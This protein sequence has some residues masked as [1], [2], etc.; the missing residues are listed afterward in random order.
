MC[1]TR[2]GRRRDRRVHNACVSFRPTGPVLSRTYVPVFERQAA[3]LG[4]PVRRPPRR[5]TPGRDAASTQSAAPLGALP[6][7]RFRRR[8]PRPLHLARARRF[9]AG[10]ARSGNALAGAPPVI[11]IGGSPRDTVRMV[12]TMILVGLVIGRWWA[13]PLGGAAWAL[14]VAVAVGLSPGDAPLAAAVGAANVAV[15]MGV[16]GLVR[17]TLRAARQ[18]LAPLARR[19]AS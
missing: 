7:P 8:S 12:P 1:G 10:R 5:P 15:G 6:P 14:L 13:I 9:A 11:A 19:G 17:L 3:R 18:L 2:W 16:R 4:G